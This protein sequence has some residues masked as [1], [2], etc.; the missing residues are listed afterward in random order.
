MMFNR[1]NIA[2]LRISVLV[3][4]VSFVQSILHVHINNRNVQIAQGKSKKADL[5]QFPIHFIVLPN[6]VFWG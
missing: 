1:Q 6:L 2:T 4:Y 5:N 3:K